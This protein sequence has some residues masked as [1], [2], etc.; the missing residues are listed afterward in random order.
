MNQWHT[1]NTEN[2][3]SRQFQT[4]LRKL[5]DDERYRERI[6][7]DPRRIADDFQF[8][9]AEL[10]MLVALGQTADD[11]S[12]AGSSVTAGAGCCCCCGGGHGGLA[13]P[14]TSAS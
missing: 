9:G 3:M 6:K 7:N 12:A 13:K 2:A 8:T 4:V 10:S 11:D 14:N 1:E 5:V